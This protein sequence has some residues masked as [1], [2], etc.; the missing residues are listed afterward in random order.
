MR[1][2]IES[3]HKSYRADG[4]MGK[5]DVEAFHS[6]LQADCNLLEANH[7]RFEFHPGFQ[8]VEHSNS[9]SK[10]KG[11]VATAVWC[12]DPVKVGGFADLIALENMY[13]RNFS[14]IFST[15]IFVKEAFRREGLSRKLITGVFDYARG[16]S[17]PSM[18]VTSVLIPDVG[19]QA[20]VR[21]PFKNIFLSLGAVQP[22]SW[23]PD[24]LI[25][26]LK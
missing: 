9:V 26:L 23:D 17:K 21:Q 25:T 5:E 19:S 6:R 20:T 15:R 3:V 10:K 1:P 24:F 2:S 22:F 12:P 7:N 13:P 4:F 16:L 11:L 18:I 14:Y 8:L